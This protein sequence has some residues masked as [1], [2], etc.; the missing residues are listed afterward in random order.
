MPPD[1]ARSDNGG[2]S[3][4][5]KSVEARLLKIS[6]TCGAKD[7]R[8]RNTLIFLLPTA[9]GLGRLRNALREVAALK[10][11]KHD[12]GSQ[13]DPSEAKE[14][15]AKLET[16]EA[17]VVESIGAAYAQVARVEGQEL[18][19][20]D[21][22]RCRGHAGPTSGIRM[23]AGRRRRRRWVVT[24]VGSVTL[25]NSGLVPSEGGIRVKDALEAFLRFTDKQM[26]ASPAAVA[27]GLAQAC[28][29]R[30]IGIGRGTSASNLQRRWCGQRIEINPTEDGLWII[31]P[32]ESE[33]KPEPRP[34]VTYPEQR[35]TEGQ[36]VDRRPRGRHATCGTQT[37]GRND[38]K[39]GQQASDANHHPRQRPD[40]KLGRHF[41]VLRQSI[42]AK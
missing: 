24:K 27:E 12:Y 23:D 1:F 38:W 10:A 19:T 20:V 5:A 15:D 11:V 21:L 2:S 18:V 25:Q 16:A 42:D 33:S 28:D 29:D 40:G 41:R 7:R 14:L 4:N 35:P 3:G 36:P 9:R 34:D 32:F 17:S 37:A 22:E 30:L 6:E 13:L 8:Y 31:P 26:I 39:A